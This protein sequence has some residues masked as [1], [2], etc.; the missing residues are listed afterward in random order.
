MPELAELLVR[1]LGVFVMR[2]AV[3]AVALVAGCESS[4]DSASQSAGDPVQALYARLN[5]DP[6]LLHADYTPAVHKLI[7]VGRPALPRAVDLM[8]TGD[9]DTRMRAQRV[10]EG[11]TSVEHGFVFGQG[12]T[13]PDG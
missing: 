3:I 12:W 11:V 5:D 13:R 9:E 4:P 10:L 2:G 7:R 6:D 1:R 8:L